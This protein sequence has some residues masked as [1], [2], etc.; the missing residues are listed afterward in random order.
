ML[1]P[2]ATQVVAMV[3]H[4]LVTNAAKHGALSI[5]TGRVLVNWERRANG[6]AEANLVFG[7][8]EVGGPPPAAEV[9]SGYGTRLIRELVPYDLGG[10]VD[11]RF[12]AEGVSC[13]IEFL[14]TQE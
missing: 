9:Q 7:W 5:P 3:L 8:R 11:L 14:L 1:F 6:H 10:T 4:E 2:V 13:R 12:A